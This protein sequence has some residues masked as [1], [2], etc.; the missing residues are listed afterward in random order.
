MHH[1]HVKFPR[2]QLDATTMTLLTALFVVAFNN[3]SFWSRVVALLGPGSA[4]KWPFLL[5]LALLLTLL[6]IMA[7]SLL[8]IRPLLKPALVLVL[9]AA[10]ACGYF[11]DAYGV[12]IDRS[13]IRNVMQTDAAEAGELLNWPLMKY[14]FLFGMVPATA[15]MLTRVR[16]RSWQRELLTRAGVILGCLALVTLLGVAKYKELVLFGRQH[17]ELRMF[18]NPSYPIYSLVTFFTRSTPARS[19]R[20]LQSPAP[21]AVRRDGGGRSAVVL[22]LGE[23]A[24]AREFALNG[25][26]RDTTPRLRGL[27]VF[28]YPDV[29]A[30]GTS[31]AESL[32][33]IFSHLGRS[34]YSSD[35]AGRYEN[36]LDILQRT[37][38]R[39]LW[40]DN[41]SGSK[42]VGARVP[43]VDLS[44][45]RDAGLCGPDGCYDEILLEGLD[46]LLADNSGD[47][48]IVLH[49]KGSH[50][51]SY[52]K[53]TPPAFKI[54]T[55]ECATDSVQD[56][57]P[58]AIVNAYDNSILYTDYVLAQL[59][60]RLQAQ[61]Y[62]TAMLYVSDHGESLGEN[63]LYLHGLPYA[64]APE[65]QKRVPLL[66]WASDSFFPTHNLDPARLDA[67]RQAAVSHDYIFHTI[68]GLFGVQTRAYRPSLDLFSS[69][70]RNAGKSRERMGYQLSELSNCPS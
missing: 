59:I 27:K 44:R 49:Q 37:G 35:K 24:R 18:L 54:F 11:M 46:D 32:P 31:T 64:I 21:D 15:I 55:P 20:P 36:L 56:C 67:T 14:L 48:F 43:C 17:H 13:M 30:C 38:V 47:L 23:T 6:L 26:P 66:F 62:P 69:C 16:S 7:L 39:V 60:D 41:N 34:D 3:H 65:E 52:Y 51:P 2:P 70:R 63:G 9:L 25:Y 29:H 5:T 1:L 58:Q 4:E 68:L 40:R 42:G 22:V 57:E 61:Q 28:N 53:R 12:A 50:G 33:C 10:A 45:S 19:D 8:A